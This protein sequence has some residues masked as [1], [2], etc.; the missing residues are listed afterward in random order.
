MFLL[1]FYKKVNIGHKRLFFTPPPKAFRRL[2][3]EAAISRRV[4]LSR[5]SIDLW[6]KKTTPKERLMEIIAL[7]D[8]S[9]TI[10]NDF[11]FFQ[12]INIFTQT[13]YIFD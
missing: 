4:L 12:I 8:T 9:S 11:H 7:I 6:V 5:K 2:L 1:K 10:F 13:C 3:G